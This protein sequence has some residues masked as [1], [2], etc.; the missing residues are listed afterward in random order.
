MGCIQAEQGMPTEIEQIALAA[1]QV[2]RPSDAIYC[3][4]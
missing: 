4:G 3:C 1:Q 2:H